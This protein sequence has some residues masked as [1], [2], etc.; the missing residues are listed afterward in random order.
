MTSLSG[1]AFSDDSMITTSQEAH[2]EQNERGKHRLFDRRGN[3]A[4]ANNPLG[5]LTE[6]DRIPGSEPAST[7][8]DDYLDK[9]RWQK[10]RK[11]FNN[12]K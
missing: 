6:S 9:P 4:D 8:R 3:A 1:V 7:Y 11:P 5:Y 2:L 10:V 12:D